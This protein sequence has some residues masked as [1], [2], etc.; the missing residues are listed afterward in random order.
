MI[1]ELYEEFFNGKKVTVMGLGVLGRGLGDTAFLA[2]S[3]S[4]VTVTDKKSKE[5]LSSSLALLEQYLQHH[6][7]SKRSL[8]S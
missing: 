7:L 6:P 3:D 1:K 4:Y 5:Y 2:Q 8:S